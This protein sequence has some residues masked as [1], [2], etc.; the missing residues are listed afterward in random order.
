MHVKVMDVSEASIPSLKQA[1]LRDLGYIVLNVLSLSYFIYLVL[2]HEYV[3]GKV[4]VVSSSPG[5]ILAFAGL[6]WFLLEVVT[7]LTNEKRRAL[8]DLIAGTVVVSTIRT[9]S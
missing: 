5:T 8:H 1:F 4:E 2:A 3:S 9:Q 6:G 7:M